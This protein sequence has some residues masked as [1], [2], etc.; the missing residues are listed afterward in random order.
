[1][2][3]ENNLQLPFKTIKMSIEKSEIIVF[4]IKF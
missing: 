3:L 4:C 1:M 2:S